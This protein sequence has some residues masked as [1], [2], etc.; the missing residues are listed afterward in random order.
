MLGGV[1]LAL[2]GGGVAAAAPAC[3]APAPTVLLERF[4]PA[5]CERCWQ[6]AT[7]RDRRSRQLVLDW[8]TP[9][10]ADAAMA[11]A[12]LPEALAR[13]R[14]MPA[15][16]T[17]Y[18]SASIARRGAPLLRISDGPGWNGYIGLR[19]V[20]TR[21]AKLPAD[22]VAYAALV[23]QVPAGSEGTAVDRQLVREL[24]GPMG[25]GELAGESRIEHLRA[26]R[27]PEAGRAERLSSV[28]W[29][30][31]AKGEVLAAAQS[32]PSACR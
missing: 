15:Q 21:R 28:A 6:E 1:A 13:A 2:A 19:L 18:R 25:L 23:E 17:L 8:I 24:V 7:P 5:D 32:A 9:G 29:I 26:V 14:T 3:D 10:A 12:A 16:Q 11:S 20:V 31:T 27:V 4:V 30:E 22:A